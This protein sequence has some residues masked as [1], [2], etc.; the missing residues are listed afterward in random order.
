MSDL[1][2]TPLYEEHL[3]LGARM[4]D[5]AG[6]SMPVQYNGIIDEH[7]A[8]RSS[9]GIFDVSHMSAFRVCGQNAYMFLQ[10]VL[11]NDLDQ[12]AECTEAQYTLILNDEGG[13]ID[14]VIVYNTGLEYLIVGNASNKEKDFKWLQ[15]HLI[16]DVELVDES[17]RTALIALQGPLAIEIMQDLAGSDWVVPERFHI[18]PAI[19]DEKINC[20]V[21]RTGYTGEDGVEIICHADDAVAVWRV[22]LSFETV[23]PVGLGARDTLRLEMGYHLYG[24]DID[25]TTNPIEANLGWVCPKSKT[26]Y[27]G[28]E[29]VA[30]MRE[31][32]ASRKLSYLKLDS[33]I[34]RPGYSVML[35]GEEIGKIASGSYSPSLETGI[36]T[37][38]LPVQHAKIDEKVQVVVRKKLIDAQVVKAPF[39]KK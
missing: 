17:D 7:I 10:K 32:G 1:L 3:G 26:G 35:E 5:F 12:I 13:I 34:P 39:Y 20:L 30:H 37:V 9:A 4:V 2:K 18:V 15:S 28:Q 21:A 8:T 22:L 27:I 14:D 16:D 31:N 24:N 25:E 33:G 36:A 29:S 6:Y 23:S 38:Y 19:I 11:S